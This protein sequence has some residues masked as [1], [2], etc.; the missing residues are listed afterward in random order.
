MATISIISDFH[1]GYGTN[2][3][4]EEDPFI[5]GKEAF[6]KAKDSDLIILPGDIFD[7]K[8]PRPE[9]WAKSMKVLN[10]GKNSKNDKKCDIL[11]LRGKDR[12]DIS[13]QNLRGIPMVA[14]HG[15]HERRGES[16]I[17]PVEGLEHAGFLIHLHCASI[18]LEVDGD[19]IGVHGMSGV[20]E[21]YAKE[22]MV[23]WDPQPFENAYNIFMLHQSIEPYIYSPNNPPSL[24]LE[25]LPTGF[26]LYVSGHIHW[27]EKTRVNEKP[28]IIP[29]STVTTQIKKLESKY[30]KGFWKIEDQEKIEFVELETPRKSY[31]RSIELNGEGLSEV[32]DLVKEELKDIL[33]EDH[34]KKPLVRINLQGNIESGLTRSDLDIKKMKDPFK[35][36]ALITIDKKLQKSK[37]NENVEKLRNI[38]NEEISVG[39]MG[40]KLLHE[41][42]EENG[43]NFNYDDIFQSLVDG[44]LE[45][46]LDTILNK[47]I[48]K[49]NKIE[50]DGQ[51]N[52]DSNLGKWLQ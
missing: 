5:V 15:T 49:D 46:V 29:G 33:K 22:V 13:E 1:F 21:K 10:E 34:N 20:P 4:R 9:V 16:L 50:R 27:K 48:K 31:N 23:E 44:N 12:E 14:I 36:N 37:R 45:T 11:E 38:R 3:E 43:S 47:K 18:L 28:F 42:L 52:K 25:D 6:R 41:N 51:K 39:E 19:R 26:D 8:I 30:N 40:M 17:N 7:S 24:K 32:E 35:E 2:T